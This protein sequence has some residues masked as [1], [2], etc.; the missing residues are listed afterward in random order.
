MTIQRGIRCPIC[1]ETIYSNSPGDVVTC[2]CDTVVVQGGLTQTAY[3]LLK[4]D[5]NVMPISRI[6]PANAP[7]SFRTERP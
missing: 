3:R 6:F 7:E 4:P 2:K 1:F 5:V